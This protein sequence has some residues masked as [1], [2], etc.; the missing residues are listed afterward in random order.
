MGLTR[1]CLLAG[2]RAVVATYWPTVDDSGDL[3]QSFYSATSKGKLRPAFALQA[4]QKAMIA[5][6]GWQNEPR[7]W[8]AHFVSSGQL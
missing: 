6:K 7:Y 1:A 3:L 2:A 4:A 8:A 5:N